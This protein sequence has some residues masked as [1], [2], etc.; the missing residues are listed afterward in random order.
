[1]SISEGK[2]KCSGTDEKS[3]HMTIVRLLMYLVKVGSGEECNWQVESKS[4]LFIHVTSGVVGRSQVLLNR[5]GDCQSVVHSLIGYCAKGGPGRW[6][7]LV[8]CTYL[9][10]GV[11]VFQISRAKARGWCQRTLDKGA[12][13]L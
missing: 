4:S 10:S 2:C 7:Q 8:H 11:R 9:W 3:D 12:G 1:V 13:I 6:L 5:R